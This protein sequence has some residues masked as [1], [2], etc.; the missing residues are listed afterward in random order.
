MSS[1]ELWSSVEE[2]RQQFQEK[3]YMPNPSTIVMADEANGKV[4]IALK[5]SGEQ[6][7]FETGARRDSQAGKPR[8]DLVPLWV[9]ERLAKWLT[10][11]AERYG[12]YNW[13]KGVPVDRCYASLRRHIAALARGQTDEDHFAAVIFNAMVIEYVRAAVLR[14]KLPASLLGNIQ[15]DLP[16]GS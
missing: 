3:L 4:E 9:E 16:E 12:D 15:L 11:G 5:S 13:A 7:R 10:K 14:G 2:I 6:D 1:D 8:Y